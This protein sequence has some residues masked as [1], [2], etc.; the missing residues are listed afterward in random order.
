MPRTLKLLLLASALAAP[1]GATA[2]ARQTPA[3]APTQQSPQADE[4]LERASR[5]LARGEAEAAAAALKPVAERRKTDERAWHYLGVA[6]VHADRGK[7]ARKAFER[8][9]K[10]RP[11]W[12]EARA[13]LAHALALSGKYAEAEEEAA[14]ALAA[15]PQRAEARYALGVV[16]YRSGR[17]AQALEEARQ[18]LLVVHIGDGGDLD[19]RVGRD[20]VRERDGDVDQAGHG[21]LS[22]EGIRVRL[23]RPGVRPGS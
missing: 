23:T 17:F 16:S 3:A 20:V 1:C 9:L 8:A 13:G 19:R 14:R 2:A 10:L 15:D 4:E 22:G 5:Q 11:E 18:A 6:Y 12:P 7:D 21:D